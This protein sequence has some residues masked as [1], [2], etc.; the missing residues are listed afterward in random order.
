MECL[1]ITAEALQLMVV[2]DS[3]TEST[4]FS[5]GKSVSLVFAN[6]VRYDGEIVNGI[7]EGLGTLRLPDGTKY[8]GTFERGLPNKSGEIFWP[9]GSHYEG[10]ILDGLRHGVGKM[11]HRFD[12]SN[13]SVY[14]GSWVHGKRSGTGTLYYNLDCTGPHYTG[15]WANDMRHG[16]G[17]VYYANGDSYAGEWQNDKKSGL[18]R[19]VWMS[20]GVCE[21]YVGNWLEDLPHGQGVHTWYRSLGPHENKDTVVASMYIEGANKG[22]DSSRPHRPFLGAAIANR[23]R[24]EFWYGFRHGTGVYFYGNGSKY[25]GEWFQNKKHGFGVYISSDGNVFEAA[26]QADLPVTNTAQLVANG[27]LTQEQ[28]QNEISGFSTERQRLQPMVP[29]ANKPQSSTADASHSAPL[30]P[31]LR[32]PLAASRPPPPPAFQ[33]PAAFEPRM[34]SSDSLYTLQ[35]DDLLPEGIALLRWYVQNHPSRAEEELGKDFCTSILSTRP[36]RKDLPTPDVPSNAHLLGLSTQGLVLASSIMSPDSELGQYMRKAHRVINRLR[37]AATSHVEATLLRWN[38]KLLGWY[39]SFCTANWFDPVLFVNNQSLLSQ[40]LSILSPNLHTD[41]KKRAAQT[42]FSRPNA[43]IPSAHNTS[44]PGIMTSPS[45]SVPI[46]QLLPQ[47]HQFSTTSAE[48]PILASEMTPNLFLVPTNEEIISSEIDSD[49]SQPHPYVDH[50]SHSLSASPALNLYYT[51][52]LLGFEM[53]D[54]V[55]HSMHLPGAHSDSDHASAPGTYT[56]VQG[57]LGPQESISMAETSGGFFNTAAG[58]HSAQEKGAHKDVL[59]LGQLLRFL[60]DTG[61]CQP[62]YA[63][64]HTACEI[65]QEIR[66]RK[67]VSVL[68][69]CNKLYV[70]SRFWVYSPQEG[71]QQT[72]QE[73]A[74]HVDQ[75]NH[76]AAGHAG[77]EHQ[78]THGSAGKYIDTVDHIDMAESM[79]HLPPLQMEFFSDE[80]SGVDV[81]GYHNTV[82]TQAQDIGSHNL[83]TSHSHSRSPSP[84]SPSSASSPPIALSSSPSHSSPPISSPPTPVPASPLPSQAQIQHQSS[85]KTVLDRIYEW[86]LRDAVTQFHAVWDPAAPVFFGEFVELLVR[87]THRRAQGISRFGAWKEAN[88]HGNQWWT[89]KAA[90][91]LQAELEQESKPTRRTKRGDRLE[92]ERQERERLEKLELERR[93]LST[94]Q[95]LKTGSNLSPSHSPNPE[96]T[97]R[98]IALGPSGGGL[99]QSWASNSTPGHTESKSR[100]VVSVTSSSALL[101]APFEQQAL[102]QW[103]R[104]NP[105][106]LAQLVDALFLHQVETLTLRVFSLHTNEPATITGGR[107]SL[108]SAGSMRTDRG[109]VGGGSRVSSAVR[110]KIPA[111]LHVTYSNRSPWTFS[112]HIA[113]DQSFQIDPQKPMPDFTWNTCPIRY[114]LRANV[115]VPFSVWNPTYPSLPSTFPVQTPMSGTEGLGLGGPLSVHVGQSSY[116]FPSILTLSYP[117]S[118]FSLFDAMID[119]QKEKTMDPLSAQNLVPIDSNEPISIQTALRYLLW[120]KKRSLFVKLNRGISSTKNPILNNLKIPANAEIELALSPYTEASHLLETAF[121]PW[122]TMGQ[123]FTVP[124]FR[125]FLAPDSPYITVSTLVAYL[126]SIGIIEWNVE[127]IPDVVVDSIA[128]DEDVATGTLGSPSASASSLPD[129][130]SARVR[131]QASAFVPSSSSFLNRSATGDSIP[132][133]DDRRKT[134]GTTAAHSTSTLP[135]A[136]VM[137]TF[138][139]DLNHPDPLEMVSP[140]AAPGGTGISK[141]VQTAANILSLHSSLTSRLTSSSGTNFLSGRNVSPTIQEAVLNFLNNVSTAFRRLRSEL[142]E[143]VR[144]FPSFDGITVLRIIFASLQSSP[145]PPNLLFLPDPKLVSSELQG[146]F[147]PQQEVW[148]AAITSTRIQALGLTSKSDASVST[149]AGSASAST[150]KASAGTMSPGSGSNA[151]PI[152]GSSSVGVPG[153]GRISIASAASRLINLQRTVG[154]GNSPGLSYEDQLAIFA[155]GNLSRA[156]R[157]AVAQA[158]STTSDAST[159]APPSI[160]VPVRTALDT[161]SATNATSSQ[162]SSRSGSPVPSPKQPSSLPAASHEGSSKQVRYERI[163]VSDLLQTKLM[164]L[165][166]EEIVLRLATAL[167][168]IQVV[169]IAFIAGAEQRL[170][171]ILNTFH[172][173]IEKEAKTYF[174]RL[175]VRRVSESANPPQ[176]AT[177]MPAAPVQTAPASGSSA[178]GATAKGKPVAKQAGTASSAPSPQSNAS[179][180]AGATQAAGSSHNDTSGSTAT[181]SASSVARSSSVGSGGVYTEEQVNQIIRLCT[182]EGRSFAKNTVQQIAIRFRLASA[183]SVVGSRKIPSSSAGIR[184]NPATGSISSTAQISKPVSAVSSDGEMT[185]P[186]PRSRAQTPRRDGSGSV[187]PSPRMGSFQQGHVAAAAVSQGS[188]DGQEAQL[189]LPSPTA[190]DNERIPFFFP[191]WKSTLPGGSIYSGPM[192]HYL[193]PMLHE[194]LEGFAQGLEVRHWYKTPVD[195]ESLESSADGGPQTPT[196]HKRSPSNL[197][198]GLV[199]NKAAAEGSQVVEMNPRYIPTIANIHALCSEMLHPHKTNLMEFANSG[200]VCFFEKMI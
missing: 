88:V 183:E 107:K 111:Q 33:P 102:F 154:N 103:R 1:G 9:D 108:G 26:F 60:I 101:G 112:S 83:Q 166:V 71:E 186:N 100:D 141:P 118:G 192:P 170:N 61:L 138:P 94:E 124:L 142:L 190:S 126:F 145:P 159:L 54:P 148:G 114:C 149:G 191:G 135:R 158:Q 57:H 42:L 161:G 123:A 65:L 97:R 7:R 27:F 58:L 51:R 41:P 188:V 163:R 178:V 37:S 13:G 21:E 151:A 89:R 14:M 153:G 44:G 156:A 3:A 147:A 133:L 15:Q 62:P 165:E 85:K 72:A 19:M 157:A 175:A 22:P 168:A 40:N 140:T 129:P 67:I 181:S 200:L 84:T 31:S 113:R 131:P 193:C 104:G 152:A 47:F 2:P 64:L 125:S 52:L 198:G 43:T 46:L 106:G 199:R 73:E 16:L 146:K 162:G 78:S 176:P 95:E 137:Q 36:S 74:V 105:E 177:P 87:L 86:I 11:T 79:T 90:E 30:Q 121:Q 144:S 53:G 77:A 169:R 76:A 80:I 174:Q 194:K 81:S 109:N 119:T 197:K 92:K 68:E 75:D 23:Y 116:A 189:A 139:S 130:Q 45:T 4:D 48:E 56:N 8:I 134:P 96:R 55:A 164:P 196:M 187:P 32:P 91:I 180:T 128:K 136:S 185:P 117:E 195:D 66:S 143:L 150:T 98:N 17:A 18:G 5:N 160:V 122:S 69:A 171:G 179:N 49:S 173:A 10:E 35:I 110:K 12:D 82:T 39:E 172:F 28:L 167:A 6:N 99:E 34:L 93:K 70:L 20:S 50:V 127:R 182:S 25:I 155:S 115:F 38:T 63:T 59:R 24:G 132:D 120:K 29:Y 184:Y